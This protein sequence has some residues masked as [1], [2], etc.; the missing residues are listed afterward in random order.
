MD[1]GKKSFLTLIALFLAPI[2]LGTLLF[3]NMDK[4]GFKKGSVNYGA[5]IQPAFPAE[6]DGLMSAG[7][8]ARKGQTLSKKW[9]MLYIETDDCK[10]LCIDRLLLMKR[11]RLLMNEQMRRVRTVLVTNIDAI[12]QS[13]ILDD[14]NLVVTTLTSPE[15]PFLEQ[16]PMLEKKPIFLLDPLG[17]L[18]MYYSQE[19]PNAKKMIKD[20]KKLLKYSRLG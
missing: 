18:M 14:N 17:N 7:K 8:P 19:K 5:L 2:V 6:A 13:K 16:F 4:M 12:K 10:Q 20:L 15:S 3:F 11:V 1:S 9:T